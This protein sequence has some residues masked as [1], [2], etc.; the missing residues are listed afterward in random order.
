MRQRLLTQLEATGWEVPADVRDDELREWALDR[1][2]AEAEAAG[3]ELPPFNLRR[4]GRYVPRLGFALA[5]DGA[6]RLR[7]ALHWVIQSLA[8]PAALYGP[9]R[10]PGEGRFTQQPDLDSPLGC[11]RWKD[12]YAVYRDVPYD[13]HLCVVLDLRC[14]AGEAGA[15]PVGWGLVPVFEPGGGHSVASGP[16][17]VPLLQGAVQP[18]LLAELAAGGG[19]SVATTVAAWLADGRARLARGCSSVL[20]RLLD[21]QLADGHLAEAAGPDAPLP[22]YVPT[23]LRP[24]YRGA[25]DSSQVSYATHAGTHA[26]ARRMVA[27]TNLSFSMASGLAI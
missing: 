8:P 1:L 11:P 26:E 6:L 12:G 21:G 2:A 17:Q 19:S 16:V 22:T 14:A 3:G 7:P 15:T 10:L 4:C 13:P 18:E 20:V 25:G 23:A 9:R 5:V 24:G 27:R